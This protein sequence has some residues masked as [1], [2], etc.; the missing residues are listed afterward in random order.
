M[1]QPRLL[2][3]EQPA[4]PCH[5]WVAAGPAIISNIKYGLTCVAHGRLHNLAVIALMEVAFDPNSGFVRWWWFLEP[6][7]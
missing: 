3:Q 5:K 2:A 7:Q 6:I 4:F 1:R